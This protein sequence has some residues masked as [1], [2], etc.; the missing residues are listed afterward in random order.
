[1]KRELSGIFHAFTGAGG[2][3]KTGQIIDAKAEGLDVYNTM[4]AAMGA[5]RRL[6][7]RSSPQAG[8]QNI[9]M[10]GHKMR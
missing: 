6:R 5:T 7:P 2:R 8:P 3:F 4:L 10:V 9:C 1:V